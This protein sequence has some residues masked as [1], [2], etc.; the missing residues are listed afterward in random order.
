M[1]G[2]AQ[3][4][5]AVLSHIRLG[6][7]PEQVT[8][9]RIVT[10]GADLL[11]RA[12]PADGLDAAIEA[13]AAPYLLTAPGAVARAKR[14]ARRLGPTIDVAVIEETVEALA[15]SWESAEA[16]EGIAAFV[17]KRKPKWQA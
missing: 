5:G 11:A 7:L 4:G 2:L 10:G 13:E 1:A 9:P 3:K 15:D 6:E 17:E 14:L 12:V 16:Q 8:S